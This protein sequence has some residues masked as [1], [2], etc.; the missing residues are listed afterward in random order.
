MLKRH[1]ILAFALTAATVG[2]QAAAQSG[3]DWEEPA[4]TPPA[5]FTGVQYVDDRGCVYVRAGVNG[6]TQWVPRVTRS[7]EQ[8]C[9]QTPTFRTTAVETAAPETPAT[10]PEA[11]PA[12]DTQT[13]SATPAPEP[14]PLPPQP[15]ATA[16]VSSSGGEATPA[17][18]AARPAPEQPLVVR[19]FPK[20]SGTPASARYTWEPKSSSVPIRYQPHSAG[21]PDRTAPVAG[22]GLSPDTW[23]VPRHVYENRLR[24]EDLHIPHGYKPVWDDGRLNRWRAWQRVQGYRDTQ[25]VWTSTVPRERILRDEAAE[26]RD[27]VITGRVQART[28]SPYGGYRRLTTHPMYD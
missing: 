21:D 24:E 18:R 6:D 19:R 3:T 28:P 5:S 13:A 20:A 27:P 26:V 14:A 8:V 16:P 11:A 17:P 25:R 10:E 2:H 7:R 12:P 4:N 23:I 15:A 9:G 1:I 22:A